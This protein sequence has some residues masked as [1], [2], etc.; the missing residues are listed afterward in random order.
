M[1]KITLIFAGL[2]MLSLAAN[3][4][5]HF[6]I[7]G[8]FTGL[9][10]EKRVFLEYTYAN[11][12]I[13]DSTVTKNGSF[14]FKGKIGADPLKATVSL[15]ELKT[16]PSVSLIQRQLI[17]DK[18]DFFLGKEAVVMK[19]GATAKNMHITGGK[20][21]MEYLELQ[22][23]QRP[24]L[25]KLTALEDELYPMVIKADGK[26]L[27]TIKRIKTLVALMSPLREKMYENELAFLKKHPDSYVSLDIVSQVRGVIVPE[28]LAAKLNGLN[29]K[30]K[31][32]EK[33]KELLAKLEKAKRTSVGMTAGDFSQPDVNGKMISLSSFRGKYVLL[34]FWA[35]WCG[36]CRAENPHVLK[37]YNQFKDKNFDIF[38]VSL[39]DH[40]DYWL[41]A[42]KEDGMPW[43]QASDLKGFRNEAATFY[44]I[45]AIPQNFLIDP[46]GVIV[47]KNLRGEELMETLKKILK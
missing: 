33:G 36:P 32:S 16:A 38:A 45:T 35:S 8:K 12:K 34:D 6:T 15:R 4:Q 17:N 41:K 22:K 2:S 39:D 24:E 29:P 43:T 19:G 26:G 37:A 30:L 20:T 3:A 31:N 46:N 9:K 28:E 40:K 14:G 21:Q 18:Q 5:D 10:V 7:N 27:D 1:K 11:K 47:A 25:N 23:I 44:A 42:V 13:A